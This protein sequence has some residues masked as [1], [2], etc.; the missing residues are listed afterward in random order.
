M[1]LNNE[2][3]FV[4]R[5]AFE[6]RCVQLIFAAYHSAINEKSISIDWNENDITMQLNEYIENNSQRIEWHISSNI[7]HHVPSNSIKKEKGFAD[8]TSRIDLR[9]VTFNELEYNYY[10]EAKRLKEKDYA[11]KKRYIETGID[12][13]ISEKYPLGCL[14][15]YF[16]EGNVDVTVSGIN[17][18]LQK[19]NRAPEILKKQSCSLHDYYYVSSHQ[20]ITIKHYILDFTVQ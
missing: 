12:N 15:A 5:T 16:L 14:V 4:F 10:M 13:Y 3:S 6:N 1:G 2:V 19:Y 8:K 20:K 18:L 17:L 7:E 9:F 11:L